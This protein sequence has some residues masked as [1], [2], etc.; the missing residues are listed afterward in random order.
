MGFGRGTGFTPADK[1]RKTAFKALVITSPTVASTTV[2]ASIGGYTAEKALTI[3][4]PTVSA[5]AAVV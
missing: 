3:P 2:A 1:W 4:T 5:V